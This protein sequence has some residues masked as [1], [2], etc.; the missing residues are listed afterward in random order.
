M[1][2]FFPEKRTKNLVAPKTHLWVISISVL[3]VSLMIS[4]SLSPL[5]ALTNPVALSATGQA[6]KEDIRLV[7]QFGATGFF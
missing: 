3:Y 7:E 1:C 5:F 6:Q 4:S 2:S